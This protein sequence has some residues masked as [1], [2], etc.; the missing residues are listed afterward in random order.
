MV[1]VNAAATVALTG[2]NVLAGGVVSAVVITNPGQGYYC[3]SYYCYIVY[4]GRLMFYSATPATAV[5]GS[6]STLT[7]YT[8]T[9]G[10]DAN[11][12]C[13]DSAVR[14]V[15]ILPM[16]QVSYGCILCR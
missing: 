10:A 7:W 13:F 2:A 15:L 12:G 1:G 5:M 16:L 3:C 8:F 6:L 4:M 14:R 11:G 9:T